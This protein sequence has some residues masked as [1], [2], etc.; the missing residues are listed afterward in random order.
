MF[1]PKRP[2][3]DDAKKMME[4]LTTSRGEQ[5]LQASA[6]G[7][8]LHTAPPVESAAPGFKRPTPDEVWSN[9]QA[10]VKPGQT[11]DVD[12]RTVASITYADGAGST[13]DAIPLA[14]AVFRRGFTITTEETGLRMAGSIT[15]FLPQTRL[16]LTPEGLKLSNDK[17]T[18]TVTSSG[19]S[20]LEIHRSSERSPEAGSFTISPQGYFSGSVEGG[21]YYF[22][23][24]PQLGRFG[25][26]EVITHNRVNQE[27][28]LEVKGGQ[29]KPL[30]NY[31]ETSFIRPGD[32]CSAVTQAS[33][34]MERARQVG[35][36]SQVR[37]AES[38]H[39]DA[40][41]KLERGELWQ[42]EKSGLECA[43]RVIRSLR[44]SRR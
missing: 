40:L 14:Q 39:R 10:Q 41:E 42:A 1:T 36:P 38:G 26:D 31:H 6:D 30:L 9:Y 29:V 33:V 20:R 21:G 34:Q 8:A 25:D 13:K 23:D 3:G 24:T 5:Q 4:D 7:V 17:M 2:I 19:H 27:G 18:E 35:S 37:R 15:G 22:E 11:E 32:A 16:E 28:E 44:R 12:A 43:D